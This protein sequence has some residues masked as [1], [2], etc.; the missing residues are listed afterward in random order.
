MN[1]N[2]L[3]NKKRAC[4]IDNDLDKGIIDNHISKE[5]DSLLNMNNK[6]LAKL[7]KEDQNLLKLS[8][9]N[10]PISNFYESSYMHKDYINNIIC[11]NSLSLIIS[12]S[13]DGVIKF[14]KKLYK[15]IVFL[16]QYKAHI[17]RVT[18]FSISYNSSKGVSCSDKDSV[19]KAYDL[20]SYDLINFVKLN[21]VPLLCEYV[22]DS[23]D[24]QDLAIVTEKD[25]P[26]MYLIKVN[27]SSI[28]PNKA[29]NINIPLKKL[30]FL[31]STISCI[32]YN[33]KLNSII[34]TDIKSNIIM[35][36]LQ[37]IKF[38][39]SNKLKQ[40]EIINKFTPNKYTSFKED[41]YNTDFK[42]FKI[43]NAYPLSLSWSL[44]GKYVAMFCYDFHVY[45]FKAKTGKLIFKSDESLAFYSEENS[46]CAKG[47]DILKKHCSSILI[48]DNLNS[49][50]LNNEDNNKTNNHLKATIVNKKL[51]TEKDLKKDFS[52]AIPGSYPFT[53]IEFDEYECYCYYSSI[54][55]IKILNIKTKTVVKIIGIN[56]NERFV[57]IALFQGEVLKINSAI[58]N[59]N[60][61][62]DINLNQ[63]NNEEPNR[64]LV[65]YDPTL[66]CLSFKKNRFYMFTKREPIDITNINTSNSS[67]ILSTLK[68]RDRYNEKPTNKEIESIINEENKELPNE[69][70]IE[71]SLGEIYIKL[72]PNEC[73]K[74]VKNF[75]SL[76]NNG[77]YNNLVFHRVI[78][79]FMIQ[80]G[81]PYG[82]GTGGES[83][84]GGEFDD[85]FSSNLKHDR[86][87][88]VSMANRGPNTNGSQFFITTCAAGWLD[89]KHT[90]FGRVYKGVD[91][92]QAI[93][94]VKCNSENKPYTDIRIYRIR[95]VKQ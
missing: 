71:S 35:F 55:G 80:T 77:Y 24:F 23:N 94:N 92:V 34:A 11:V 41:I 61:I 72:Y 87:F 75:I 86:P 74:T 89:N 5:S 40:T 37:E 54:L 88:T 82:N 6:Q 63:A 84:W 39:K 12:I 48:N 58:D 52:K 46:S 3:L 67:N 16:K 13:I 19:L 76:A 45:I 29:E 33:Y 47:Y 26:Y 15:E 68:K 42:I 31:D 4:N 64:K 69:A 38:F 28:E 70:I 17:G 60:S 43:N 30:V 14:W 73:P 59:K 51:K 50:I 83:I 10:L 66:V 9:D 22:N 1:E 93:E 49:N 65:Y 32:K 20:N 91:T 25:T 44:K 2:V 62:N 81:C 21:F 7:T 36:D 90:V 85:E 27:N 95:T 56:E 8:L 79:D 53:N 78:K 57:K 18:G